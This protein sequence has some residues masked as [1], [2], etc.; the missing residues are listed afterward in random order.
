VGADVLEAPPHLASVT[1]H[2]QVL[3]QQDHG[4]GDLGVEVADNEHRVPL[5][6]IVELRL[7]LL[8]AG[9]VREWVLQLD[10]R[11]TGGEVAHCTTGT[12]LTPRA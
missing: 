6:G 9:C 7:I 1:P 2:D 11:G 4:R 10:G 3:A 5:P 12:A 8:H